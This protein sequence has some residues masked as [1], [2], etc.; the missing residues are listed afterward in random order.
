MRTFP[1]KE[2]TSE[3]REEES[4]ARFRQKK[5][6]S[7]QGEKEKKRKCYSFQKGKGGTCGGKEGEDESLVVKKRKDTAVGRQLVEKYGGTER[8]SSDKKGEWN[9]L[10]K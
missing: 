9:F 3:D 4:D 7:K 1:R 2:A 6:A 8:S 10:S 5:N